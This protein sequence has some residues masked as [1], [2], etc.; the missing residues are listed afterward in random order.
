MFLPLLDATTSSIVIV[1]GVKV[2]GHDIRTQHKIHTHY[3]YIYAVYRM[4]EHSMTIYEMAEG[5]DLT[6]SCGG[7]LVFFLL[8]HRGRGP[9]VQAICVT[10]VAQDPTC[11]L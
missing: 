7:A 2:G 1:E 11:T 6:L 4:T 3:I 5:S 9:G 8:M 10:P